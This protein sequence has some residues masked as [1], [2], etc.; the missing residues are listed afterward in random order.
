[1]YRFLLTPRWIGGLALAAVV[2]AVCVL[3]GTWQWD[4][5]E[6]AAA[7]NAPV[8]ANYDAAPVPV[9]DVP[10]V[11]DDVLPDEAEWTPVTASGTY[12]AERTLLVRNRPLNGRP[13]YHVLVP[14]RLAS[15]GVLVV[16]RGWVPTGATGLEPDVVPPPPDGEVEVVVRL[17]PPEP[18]AERDAP[19]GQVHRIDPARV[20]DLLPGEDVVG[21]AYGVLASE[22]P[23]PDVAPVLL[24]RPETTEG[25]HLSYSLQ[26]F[27]F[28]AGAFVAYGVL[29]R[30]TARDL[31]AAPAARPRH[32]PSAE[33]E[34]DAL[35]DAA[36]AGDHG[37]F[38]RLGGRSGHG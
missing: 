33:D 16:D 22:Q 3:L 34:E 1:M 30:R 19:P 35:V 28:A 37:R 2:A 12:L 9:Q 36:N 15:G 23:G 32:R 27:V 11:G 17:R 38:D 6:Q 24:P 4:R 10:A 7:R 8:V 14:L 18:P 20:A 5:R 13:G 29:A 21:G 26:W 31:G 25:P